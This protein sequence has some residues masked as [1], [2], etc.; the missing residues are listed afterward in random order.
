MIHTPFYSGKIGSVT[1]HFC[2]IMFSYL[3]LSTDCKMGSD[4]KITVVMH[5]ISSLLGTERFFL[6]YGDTVVK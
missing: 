2:F 3:A 1:F 6:C 4:L 5:V